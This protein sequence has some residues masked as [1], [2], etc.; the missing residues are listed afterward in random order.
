MRTLVLDTNVVLDLFVFADAR[1]GS[2]QAELDAGQAQWIATPRM[3][4]ELTRVLAYA[5]IESR[6][7]YYQLSAPEV[8][9]RFDHYVR[10]VEVPER[11]GVTCRDPD[12]QMFIDLAVAHKCLLISKDTAVLSMRKR[13]AMLD[14]VAAA[15]LP[16]PLPDAL[17]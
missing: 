9:A 13:L 7:A 15:I 8:L 14:V 17:G 1:T 10:I 3:R 5:H 16:A 4:E 6:L 2:L 12:D 11:A